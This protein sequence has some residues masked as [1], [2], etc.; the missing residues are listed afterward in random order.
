MYHDKKDVDTNPLHFQKGDNL[1]SD[2]FSILITS[3]YMHSF[4]SLISRTT[5]RLTVFQTEVQSR[6]FVSTSFLS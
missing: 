3:D 5:L 1:T 2:K 4:L 6:G